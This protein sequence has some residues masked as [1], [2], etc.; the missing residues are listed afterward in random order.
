MDRGER[1]RG[2]ETGKKGEEE[3]KEREQG[4]HVQGRVKCFIISLYNLI[5]KAALLERETL[6]I[7]SSRLLSFSFTSLHLVADSSVVRFTRVRSAWREKKRRKEERKANSRRGT[8]K[9]RKVEM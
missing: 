5:A 1:E 9:K 4:V 8:R 3:V 7:I 2:M 6:L